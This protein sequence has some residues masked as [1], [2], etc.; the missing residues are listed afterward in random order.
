MF[1]RRIFYLS[2]FDPRGARFYHALHREQMAAHATKTGEEITTSARMRGRGMTVDWTVSSAETTTRFTFLRWDDLVGRA[3]IKGP[4]RLSWRM[5]AAYVGYARHLRWRTTWRLAK[6][7]VVTLVYPLAGLTLL[8]LVVALPLAL[9]L[10][11]LLPHVIAWAIGL[12]VGAAVARRTL[13]KIRAFWLVRLFIHSDG[14]A[15][16]GFDGDTSAR[17]ESFAEAIDDALNGSEDEVLLVAHSNGSNLAVPLMLAL[18]ARRG[19]RLPARFTLVTLG[20]CVPLLGSRRDAG[21]FHAMLREL[22][23]HG[24][25]WIDIGSPADGAAFWL[26]DPLQPVASCGEI[27]LTLLNPRFYRFYDPATYRARLADRY[28]LHFDYL[29]SGDRISPLDFP[30]L[31]VG[32]RPIADAVAMFRQLP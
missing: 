14:I 21:A 10:G 27:R 3:W 8:P 12:A 13:A 32:P 31:T 9:L 1:S 19:G 26:V 5:A 6:G 20:H 11:M 24:F 2:G 17:I 15:R 30:S 22:S 16:H 23:G 25:D 4:A 18:L 7:P 29:R 28:E